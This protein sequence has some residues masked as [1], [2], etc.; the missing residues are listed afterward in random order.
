MSEDA[1]RAH[2]REN[3][4]GLLVGLTEDQLGAALC[5]LDK[6]RADA[7]ERAAYLISQ[8]RKADGELRRERK[9]KAPAELPRAAAADPDAF[10][11]DEAA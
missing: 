10:E 5:R 8:K 9:P 7:I 4:A 1:C 3:F 2:E 11:D 6:V